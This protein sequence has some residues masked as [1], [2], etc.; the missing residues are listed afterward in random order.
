MGVVE[1]QEPGVKEQKFYG[2]WG[3]RGYGGDFPKVAGAGINWE[4]LL[5][6]T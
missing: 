6:I 1:G 3:E 4:T 2:S 5:N